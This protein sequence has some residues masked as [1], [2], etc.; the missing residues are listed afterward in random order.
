MVDDFGTYMED[1]IQKKRDS[2]S[3]EEII[4]A[5]RLIYDLI[6]SWPQLCDSN[7]H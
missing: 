4:G 3:G 1:L 6:V 5:R 7:L 2:M